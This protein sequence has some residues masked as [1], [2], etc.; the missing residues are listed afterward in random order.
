M[1]VKRDKM[2]LGIRVPK[3][4]YD[5]LIKYSKKYNVSYSHMG[6]DALKLLV[7]TCITPS[8]EERYI[9]PKERQRRSEKPS[10]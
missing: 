4:L 3:W 10:N 6:R 7:R 9:N 5:E 1:R 8:E 2:F